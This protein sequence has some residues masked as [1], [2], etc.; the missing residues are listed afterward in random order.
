MESVLAYG[1]VASFVILNHIR[2]IYNFT[3]TR[4]RAYGPL[5]LFLSGGAATAAADNFSHWHSLI[6]HYTLCAVA[7][8]AYGNCSTVA[9]ITLTTKNNVLER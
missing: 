5:V 8:H 2:A 1:R 6:I 9:R 3:E 4:R 7:H